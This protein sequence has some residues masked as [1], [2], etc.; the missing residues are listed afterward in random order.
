MKSGSRTK[1]ELEW[2]VPR[3]ERGFGLIYSKQDLPNFSS[4]ASPEYER[5]K[6]MVESKADKSK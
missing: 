3:D 1:M 6:S 5:N 2:K 4:A